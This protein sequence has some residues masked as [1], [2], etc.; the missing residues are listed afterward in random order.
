[1][2][3][4]SLGQPGIEIRL[5]NKLLRVNEPV[6]LRPPTFQAVSSSE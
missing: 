5:V 6:V 4:G 3:V 2:K 1:M